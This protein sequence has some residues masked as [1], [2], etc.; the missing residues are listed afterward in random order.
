MSQADV[1]YNMPFQEYLQQPEVSASLLKRI[2]RSP[3]AARWAEEHPE[4]PTGTMVLGSALH[5]AILEPKRF[6]KE[7]V[8][9]HGTRRGKD[10]QEFQAKHKEDLILYER[11]MEM[12]LA[13]QRSVFQHPIAGP[14]VSSG[15]PEVSIFHDGRKCRV[16]LLREDCF[17]DLKTTT[18]AAPERFPSIFVRLGYDIQAAWYADLVEAAVG[19]PMACHFIAIENRAPF[20]VV[21][22]DVPDAVLAFGRARYQ[23]ALSR[24]QECKRTGRWPGYADTDVVPLVLPAWAAAAAAGASDPITYEGQ[25]LE[26]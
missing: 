25:P 12:V 19:H 6:S 17:I 26:F 21:V 9:Y 11:D 18:D 7:V 13:M 15:K 10:W 2:S 4:D 23:K 14:L 20:D 3:R 22:F 5:M 24:L 8:V 1:I 16:D